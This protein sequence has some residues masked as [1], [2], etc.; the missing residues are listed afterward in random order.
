MWNNAKSIT[1]ALIRCDVWCWLDIFFSFCFVD[2]ANSG[3][4]L[5]YQT[6]RRNECTSPLI[7]ISFSVVMNKSKIHNLNLTVDAHTRHW[8]FQFSKP[9]TNDTIFHYHPFLKRGRNFYRSL[10]RYSDAIISRIFLVSPGLCCS[11]TTC[12]CITVYQWICRSSGTSEYDRIIVRCSQNGQ[13]LISPHFEIDPERFCS[14]IWVYFLF[15][16]LPAILCL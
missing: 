14:E 7:S 11:E 3:K 6:M 12:I 10:T 13:W 9:W 1:S 15:S 4:P 5:F 2:S 16:P 8:I